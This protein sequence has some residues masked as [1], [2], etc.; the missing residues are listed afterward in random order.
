M[1]IYIAGPMTGLPDFN[2]PAFHQ[3]AATLRAAGYDVINPAENPAP[4]C[5]SW[6]GYM[7]ISVA[8]VASVDCLVMLPGWQQS[9]GAKIEHTLAADLG[10]KIFTMK[11]Q[12]LQATPGEKVAT[13]TAPERMNPE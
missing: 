1:K 11:L 12:S 5:G 9:R 6:Q 10:L 4:P 8:Q 2:Y 7:C 3:V 13:T